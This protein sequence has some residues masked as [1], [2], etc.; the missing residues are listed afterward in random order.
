MSE[1]ISDAGTDGRAI[2]GGAGDA[3]PLQAVRPL[4]SSLQFLTAAWLFG[5]VWLTATSGAPLT[6]FAQSLGASKFQF[7]LLAALPFISSLLSMPASLLIDRTGKRKKIFL[8]GLYEQRLSWFVIALVPLLLVRLFGMEAARPHAMAAFLLLVFLMHCGQAVGGPAW[9]SWMAD[10]VPDR[11][12]GRY[13]GRRRSWGIVTAIPTALL[14]GWILDSLLPGG[15]AA[16]PL[17]T[18]ICCAMLFMCAAVCGAMDIALHHPIPEIPSRPNRDVSVLAGFSQPLRDP[19]FLWFA[20][21]VA[22]L[23]FAVSF[24]GQ[25]VTLYV[26][27]KLNV[28]NTGTQL[29]LIVAP[30]LAQLLVLSGW[31]HACDR[32]GKKPVMAIASLGLVPV[33]LAWCF[34]NDGA[35]WLGYLLSGLGAAL[36]AGVEVA[37]LNVVL[38]MAGSDDAKGGSRASYVAVNSV[39]INIAGCLGGLG[40]GLLAE[41]LGDRTF[42]LGFLGLAPIGFYEVLFAISG[43]MRLLAVVVFLPRLKEPKARPTHE[44][45]RFMTSNIYNNLFSA[46]FLP[47]RMLNGR[48]RREEASIALD[49]TL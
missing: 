4:R 10:L 26:I 46:V 19:Q 22:S 3:L 13:F 25:F 15:A 48:S 39:I 37:N 28:T 43:V 2:G 29:M 1:G 31:G 24:M 23:T 6:Q 11:A 35:I 18:L 49:Q 42:E 30:S 9:V 36:W 47:M 8:F 21:F 5:S 12:R 20:G 44:A 32:M 34:M 17:R 45:L 38:E 41:W 27:D 33:G 7:G 40:S 16:D 14:V